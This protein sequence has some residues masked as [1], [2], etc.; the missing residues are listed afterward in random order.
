M[1]RQINHTPLRDALVA[2]GVVEAEGRMLYQ[3]YLNIVAG[4]GMTR[5]TTLP[6]S[7]QQW[8]IMC[9]ILGSDRPLYA[10]TVSAML[11]NLAEDAPHKP[12]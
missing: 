6:M 12:A 5:D 7:E 8:E 9:D 11:K 10:S 4:D 3:D 1:S 2:A